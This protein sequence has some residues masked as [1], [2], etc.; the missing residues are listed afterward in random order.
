MHGHD[1]ETYNV[2]SDREVS[3][4]QLAHL[5]RDLLAPEK[6]VRILGAA[7]PSAARNRY[8]PCINKIKM[9]HDMRVEISLEQAILS[10]ANAH[11]KSNT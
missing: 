5:V 11:R 3:I 2:G 9:L 10:A 1:G 6:P 7:D 8:V 4:S